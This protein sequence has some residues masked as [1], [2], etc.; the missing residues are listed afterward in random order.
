[1]VVKMDIC[2]LKS[3]GAAFREKL[4]SLLHN[5]RYTPSKA[6]PDLWT[7]IAIK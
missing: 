3:S 4:A 2:G 7:R 6:Y 5:I 1:M